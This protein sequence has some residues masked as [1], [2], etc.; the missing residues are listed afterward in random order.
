MQDEQNK[1]EQGEDVEAHHWKPSPS[2]DEPGMH[3]HSDDPGMHS[4]SDDEDDVE[5]HHWKAGPSERFAD[6]SENRA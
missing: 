2:A 1:Q 3:S 6:G 4:H 5:A